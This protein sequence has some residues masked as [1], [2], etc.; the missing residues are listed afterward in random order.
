MSGATSS[1]G[2]LTQREALQGPV[3]PSEEAGTPGCFSVQHPEVSLPGLR[4]RPLS[5]SLP[6]LSAPQELKHHILQEFVIEIEQ[7]KSQR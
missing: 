4:P 5:S 3:L 6:L 7:K 2:A 1:L